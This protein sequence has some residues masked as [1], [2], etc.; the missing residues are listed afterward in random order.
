MREKKKICIELSA[1]FILL[2]LV[3][4]PNILLYSKFVRGSRSNSNV[5]LFSRNSDIPLIDSLLV[6]Q[7]A[8]SL[9]VVTPDSYDKKILDD[10]NEYDVIIIDRFLPQNLNELQTLKSHID[11]TRAN[12]GLIFFGFLENDFH[13]LQIQTISDLLPVKI[14]PHY[15][16][17]IST[18]DTSQEDYKVQITLNN[19][20]ANIS[21]NSIVKLVAWAS[22]PLIAK[23]LIVEN[24]T[25]N[26]GIIDSLHSFWEGFILKEIRNSL[27]SEQ[28][29]GTDGGKVL[30]FS[31]EIDENNKPFVLWPY[32]NYLMYVSIFHVKPG[33][34]D[35]NIET[36]QAWSFSP[37]PHMT[38]ILLW[39]SMIAVIW[40]I[41]FY[42]YF[43]FKKIT[44]QY[45]EKSE[46]ILEEK[47]E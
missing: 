35:N 41:T 33:Y 9:E 26:N 46:V 18:N 45:N 12:K 11:G 40:I 1:F 32:F 7:D 24:K 42:L 34:D 14:N 28:K 37:I 38:E 20:I 19:D 6:D 25:E 3:F 29:V 44:Q 10:L 5:I 39:F 27:I 31:M 43:K 4:A 15:N 36:Y 2:L 30:F 23:R 16:D 21:E 13:S 8:I 22:C 17:Q 47:R